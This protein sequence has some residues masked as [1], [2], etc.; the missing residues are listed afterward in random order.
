MNKVILIG[1]VGQQPE[2]RD[3]NGVQ[4]LKLSLA[5][6]KKWKV[7]GEKKEK[8]EWHTVIAWRGLAEIMAKYVTKGMK[9]AVVGSIEYGDYTDKEGVKR[10]FTSINADDIEMLTFA[11]KAT[12]ASQPDDK[13]L[14]F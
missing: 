12:P 3:V 1:N 6:T 4:M 8:T 14:P 13:D 9:L 5:T 11:D 2:I 10:Y 7:D